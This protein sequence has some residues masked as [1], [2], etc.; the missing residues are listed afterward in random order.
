MRPER[1]VESLESRKP[2]ATLQIRVRNTMRADDGRFIRLPQECVRSAGGFGF[3]IKNLAG[4]SE[5]LRN[6]SG[7]SQVNRFNPSH[8]V[9]KPGA[10]AAL[11][12]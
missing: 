5:T 8:V 9:A 12:A 11:E 6:V 2:N 7:F 3:R 1:I 10:L 4:S